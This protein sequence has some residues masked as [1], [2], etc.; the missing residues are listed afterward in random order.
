MCVVRRADRAPARAARRRHRFKVR[1]RTYLDSDLAFVEVKTKGRAGQTIKCRQAVERP[2]GA[3]T[4]EVR[5]RAAESG[6]AHAYAAE[7]VPTLT[8][9]Y[10]RATLLLPDGSARV[11]LDVDFEAT[12]PSG[13][14]TALPD[15]A[16]VETKSDGAPTLVDRLLWRAGHRP[17]RFS[18]FTTALAA[19]R[20]DLPANRWHRVLV[21]HFGRPPAPSSA[22]R[23]QL[24]SSRPL[25]V[26]PTS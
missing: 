18:K 24:P 16:I 14:R 17:V 10:R 13:R 20:P 7:L 12:D 22:T 9:T 26:S 23:A 15:V 8:T 21:E 1:T 19:L 6:P 5:E 4:T 3:T 2:G 11:T 25:P